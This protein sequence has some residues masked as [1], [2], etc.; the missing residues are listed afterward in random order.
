MAA[1]WGAFMSLF[2]DG[3]LTELLRLDCGGYIVSETSAV[4]IRHPWSNPKCD[5]SYRKYTESP[6]G[7]EAACRHDQYP[8]NGR[9][10][11][12]ATP[13]RTPN[14]RVGPDQ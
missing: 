12:A 6:F 2:P 14:S 4:P 7:C 8:D 11:L 1:L 9:A 3:R 5:T 10:G 13:S